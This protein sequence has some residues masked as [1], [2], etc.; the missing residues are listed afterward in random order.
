[1]FQWQHGEVLLLGKK[2]KKKS[3]SGS[4]I[5]ID[6]QKDNKLRKIFSFGFCGNHAFLNRHNLAV[7][8]YNRVFEV[9]LVLIVLVLSLVRQSPVIK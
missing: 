2:K 1:M 3:Y 6:L 4:F 7:S 9:L 8:V 5:D